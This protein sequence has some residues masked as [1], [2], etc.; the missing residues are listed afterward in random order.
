VLKP[1]GA[2]A[3]LGQARDLSQPLQEAVQEIVGPHL[4]DASELSGWREHLAASGL[5]VVVLPA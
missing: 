4:L 5:D 3:V 1:D 2:L